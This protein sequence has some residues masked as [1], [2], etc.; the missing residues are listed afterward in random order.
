[1]RFRGFWIQLQSSSA[2]L[3]GFLQMRLAIATEKMD[4]RGRQP[5]PCGSEIRINSNGLLKHLS[6]KRYVLPGPLLEELA[7]PQIKFVRLDV[8]GGRFDQMT[9]AT[10]V[11]RKTQ[12]I[13][14]AARDFILNSEDVSDLP[15][16]SV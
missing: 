12:S 3:A 11:A 8:G 9:P 6:T 10:L 15:I 16:D 5:G 13:N 14:D 2:R 7:T 1:M 4:M